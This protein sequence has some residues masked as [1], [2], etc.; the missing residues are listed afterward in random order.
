M[1]RTIMAERQPEHGVRSFAR[2][3]AS[4][5]PEGARVLNVGAGCNLSGELRAVRRR[6]GVLVGV[7]PHESIRD[8]TSLDQRHQGTLEDF[9]ADHPGEFDLAFSVF[10]LE[11]VS[12]PEGFTR[13]CARVLKPGCSFMAITVNLWHYFGLCSWTA[14]RLGVADRLLA[15]LR[16]P[17]EVEEYHFPTEY[18]L[19]SVGAISDHLESAGFRSV[20]FRCWDLPSMYEPY[21]PERLGA[22]ARLYSRGVYAVGSPQLM[23]HITCQ[24]VR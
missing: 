3:V 14:N 17:D 16:D 7:D 6:A 10:V 23:G 9:A 19:N 12:D 15:R 24:A 11:H 22:F 5:C 21:L 4:E 18:R 2:W 8:N 1:K 20:D 13:A